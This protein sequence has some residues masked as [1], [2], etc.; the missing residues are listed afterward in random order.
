VLNVA[1]MIDPSKGRGKTS[2]RT[3]IAVVGIDTRENKYAL[4][5]FCNRM[6][7]SERWVRVRDLHKRWSRMPGV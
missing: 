7:L 4:D 1:I 5:G 6:P 2:D 3:A